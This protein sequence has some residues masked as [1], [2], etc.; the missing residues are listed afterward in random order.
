MFLSTLT[1][2]LFFTAIGSFWDPRLVS[3]WILR[4]WLDNFLL[5]L[6]ETI[7]QGSVPIEFCTL[8]WSWN[9]K[10]IRLRQRSPL[11]FVWI[12][13]VS[14]DFL[15][16]AWPL[17]TSITYHM[18]TWVSGPH[19][20]VLDQTLHDLGQRDPPKAPRLG[21]GPHWPKFPAMS[22]NLTKLHCQAG[23][24]AP[25]KAN[26]TA[27]SSNSTDKRCSPF[28]TCRSWCFWVTDRGLCK[29]LKTLSYIL[30]V[31]CC[32]SPVFTEWMRIKASDCLGV[33]VQYSIARSAHTKT[34]LHVL[35]D[36]SNS[37]HIAKRCQKLCWWTQCCPNDPK[38]NGRS[39]NSQ[40]QPQSKHPHNNSCP[41]NNSWKPNR[42]MQGKNSGQLFGSGFWVRDLGDFARLPTM[43]NRLAN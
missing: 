23:W 28:A 6:P 31:R 18:V 29:Q 30:L 38:F 13:F 12:S 33:F 26:A 5:T 37:S 11:S 24:K 39:K 19:K 14:F 25:G 17:G 42:R 20:Y 41:H 16:Y 4:F 35:S 22:K 7:L 43:K 2:Q 36:S 15:Q 34:I 10:K 9:T 27:A 21:L 3:A 32:S 40:S 8:F 1:I